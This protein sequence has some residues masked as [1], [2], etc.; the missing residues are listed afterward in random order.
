MNTAIGFTKLAALSLEEGQLAQANQFLQKSL[1]AFANAMSLFAPDKE[2]LTSTLFFFL[3]VA[4]NYMCL[5]LKMGLVSE[6]KVMFGRMSSLVDQENPVFP[7]GSMPAVE[8][9]LLNAA[10][11]TMTDMFATNPAAAA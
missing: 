6:A 3:L 10:V 7:P 1:C 11:L 2:P 5:C 4:Q 8:E 9:I